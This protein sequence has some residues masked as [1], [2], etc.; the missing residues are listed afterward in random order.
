MEVILRFRNSMMVRNFFL[1]QKTITPAI[2]EEWYR[3]EV[4]TGKA[5]QY[6]ILSK[7][8]EPLGV[9]YISRI[10]KENHSGEWGIYLG[11]RKAYGSGIAREAAFLL[12]RYAFQELGFHKIRMRA[13]AE[14]ERSI[15]YHASV[16]FEREGYLKDEVYIDDCFKDVVIGGVTA[17]KWLAFYQEKRM[18]ER[19]SRTEDG[20]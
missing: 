1:Y 14:N 10:D 3:S 11:E 19:A 4:L 8:K 9:C 2:H 12:L 5:I 6:M 18:A 20:K 15:K 17:E 7:E 16:G 13:L